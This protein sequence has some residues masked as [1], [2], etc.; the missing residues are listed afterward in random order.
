MF[1]G[2]RK[3]G[4]GRR[5]PCTPDPEATRDGIIERIAL[6]RLATPE[7][8]AHVTLFLASDEA[9]FITGTYI[10][11]DGGQLARG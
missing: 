7:D 8:I 6:K 10:L 11:V 9:A 5:P 3:N 4:Q 1:S 2:D